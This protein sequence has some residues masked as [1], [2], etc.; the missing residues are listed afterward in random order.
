VPADLGH[1]FRASGNYREISM[2]GPL[3]ASQ[4]PQPCRHDSG[5]PASIAKPIQS[6]MVRLYSTSALSAAKRSRASAVSFSSI[7]ASE[8]ISVIGAAL[9]ILMQ[10]GVGRWWAVW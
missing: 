9:V 6:C 8:G 7:S 1:Q 2:A 4:G 10:V 3:R 5:K